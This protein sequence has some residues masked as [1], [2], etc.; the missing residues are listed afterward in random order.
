MFYKMIGPGLI[1]ALL[2]ACGS[3]GNGYTG[4]TRKKHSQRT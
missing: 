2:A 1:L 4:Y 3:S